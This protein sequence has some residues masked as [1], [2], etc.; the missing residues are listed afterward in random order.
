MDCQA[1]GARVGVGDGVNVTV[2]G[3]TVGE[4]NSVGENDSVGVPV[5]AITGTTSVA[6]FV[7]VEEDADTLPVQAVTTPKRNPVI[8]RIDSFFI[9]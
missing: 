6:I 3:S 7:D 5:E 9:S 8:K 4:D 1:S 2:A